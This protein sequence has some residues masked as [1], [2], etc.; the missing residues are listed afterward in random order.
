MRQLTL[1]AWAVFV[2]LVAVILAESSL[3]RSA[4]GVFR[5]RENKNAFSRPSVHAKRESPVVFSGVRMVTSEIVDNSRKRRCRRTRSEDQIALESTAYPGTGNGDFLTSAAVEEPETEW[6]G[7][8]VQTQPTGPSVKSNSPQRS[9]N[10]LSDRGAKENDMGVTILYVQPTFT[11]DN[12]ASHHN[13]EET[14]EAGPHSHVRLPH[15]GPQYYSPYSGNTR[16]FLQYRH[17]DEGSD[18]YLPYFRFAPSVHQ[19][20]EKET[21][22]FDSARNPVPASYGHRG[23]HMEQRADLQGGTLMS[24]QLM[25][26]LPPIRKVAGLQ[27]RSKEMEIDSTGSNEE[28]MKSMQEMEGYDRTKE[29]I[30]FGMEDVRSAEDSVEGQ[31]KVEL[32]EESEVPAISWYPVLKSAA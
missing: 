15:D 20:F 6:Q 4:S 24:A 31:D 7:K 1:V 16:Y 27:G 8:V 26:S 5:P 28:D 12:S 19:Q 3:A 30:S 11:G 17:G 10:N 2:G 22:L 32:E 9:T 23:A 21:A 18:S 29:G 25:D 14:D 13:H